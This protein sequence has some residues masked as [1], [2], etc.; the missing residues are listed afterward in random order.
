MN[1]QGSILEQLGLKQYDTVSAVVA[2]L[3]ANAWDADAENVEIELPLGKFLATVSG[4]DVQDKGFEIVVRDDGH[5]MSPNQA[6][7]KFLNVGRK[8]REEE[9]TDTSPEKGRKLMGRKGIGK[10]AP[11]GLCYTI[12]VRSAG[13]PE[14]EDGYEVSHFE[15]V[16]EDIE[17]SPPGDPY[18]P[19]PL[20]DNGSF[21]DESGTEIRLKDFDHK[22]VPS[23]GDF[24]NML[25][26]RFAD[27]L[28]D[29]SIEIID[30]NN[31]YGRFNLRETDQPLRDKTVID[32]SNYPIEIE[33]ESE[34]YQAEGKMGLATQS[35]D[36]DLQGVRIYV[37]GKLATVTRDFK[38]PSGFHM[39]NTIRSYLVGEIHCDFLDED[40]DCIQ[41]N[42]QDILWDTKYGRSL[43]EWGQK[44]V[45]EVASKSRESSRERTSNE[46]FEQTDFE[47]RVEERFKDETMVEAGKELGKTL[48]KTLDEDE[49]DDEVF[50]NRFVELIL[51]VT[52][53]DRILRIFREIQDE[54]DSGSLEIE[55]LADLIGKTSVAETYSLAQL[56]NEKVE[57]INKLE[58][59]INQG[60]EDESQ[61]QEIVENATWL[62]NPEWKP[63][64][65][66]EGIR[67]FRGRFESWYEQEYEEEISTT[68]TTAE[69]KRP[70]F[71]M[72]SRGNVL[73]VIEIKPPGHTFRSGDLERLSN[74]Y[75]AFEEFEESNQSLFNR[76]F[77]DGI[78]F[79]LITDD[80]GLSYK[81]E[82]LLNGYLDEKGY[83]EQPQSW[84][85]VLDASRAR[86]NE[87]LEAVG[88]PTK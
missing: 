48:S 86:Y 6:D 57:V 55:T 44:L 23:K 18:V 39:E 47:N 79:I 80:V 12:E 33:D 62:L 40:M 69:S 54:A 43:K 25:S 15:M 34:T 51:Q 1:I 31:E 7:D 45:R 56:A 16:Y 32:V 59:K 67:R 17:D 30:T 75:R 58:E 60:V 10:L 53:H 68:T 64:S 71:V 26:Y 74:Y 36:N 19:P 83:G 82:R 13:G 61:F 41:A 63:L 8:R 4:G 2:E 46:F 76:R 29:F 35:Y 3:V 52:P 72:V 38:I 37:R 49:L 88:Q 21:D 73:L 85:E 20:E 28:P 9:D 22:R 84:D 66:D 11:F 78:R 42:R 77:P 5:G 24:A 65:S 81:N 50:L 70:D 87:F 27:G 14:T